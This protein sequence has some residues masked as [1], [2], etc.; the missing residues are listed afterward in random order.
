MKGSDVDGTSQVGQGLNAV[1]L[2]NAVLCAECD[3]VL[4]E[5]Y[6]ATR[7]SVMCVNAGQ[8]GAAPLLVLASAPI[9]KGLFEF[10]WLP[11][12]GFGL[13]NGCSHR[14]YPG[15]RRRSIPRGQ[16]DVTPFALKKR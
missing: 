3:V 9:I 8:T 15:L 14:G 4:G 5:P 1:A 6:P 2:Q 13:A 12:E 7:A 16:M 10:R 11:G